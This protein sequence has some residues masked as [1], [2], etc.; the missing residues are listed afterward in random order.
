MKVPSKTFIKIIS[1][2]FFNPIL[3]S[4]QNLKEIEQD[5]FKSL[6][7][8][9]DLGYLSTRT[10]ETAFD[11]LVNE[12]MV[13]KNKLITYASK[14]KEMLSYSFPNLKT[15]GFYKTTSPDS[16]F[17]IYSWDTQTG[18]SM[19]FYEN[20][21]QYKQYDKLYTKTIIKEEGTPGG[22]YTDI[23]QLTDELNTFYIASY[24][25]I[26]SGRDCYQAVHIFDFEKDKFE[27]TFKKIKTKSGITNVLGFSYDFFSVIDKKERPVKLIEYNQMLQTISIPLVDVSGKVTSKRIIYKYD[28]DYF[29]K[30]I[31]KK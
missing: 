21:F 15:L 31:I 8:I 22:F 6:K 24:H 19:K 30:E 4:A 7:R 5:L 25:R 3:I 17:C 2:L 26:L 23:Y 29:V 10:D 18:G 20:V 11:S 9:D 16:T 27:P 14:N 28:G 12:N 1:L 13:L